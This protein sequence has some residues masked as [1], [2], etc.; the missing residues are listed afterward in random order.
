MAGQI[1][2]THPFEEKKEEWTQY[3]EKLVH[4]FT[5]N[6]HT[7]QENK[8]HLAHSYRLHI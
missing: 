7:M 3:V 6:S 5:A 1:G 4:F 8:V 2:I